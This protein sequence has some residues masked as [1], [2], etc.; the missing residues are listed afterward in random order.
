MKK[1]IILACLAIFGMGHLSMSQQTTKDSLATQ[2]IMREAKAVS[3]VEQDSVIVPQVRKSPMAVAKFTSNTMYLKVVYGQP[4]KRGR[5]IFGELEPYGKVWRTGAN[6]ATEITATKDF[7]IGGK[8]L[9]AGTY[10]LFTIP[11]ENK[12]TV[13]VNS[14]LGQWGAYKYNPEKDLV[15][16]EVP[17]TKPEYF[18]E[19]FTIEFKDIPSGAEMELL[20]GDT[21]VAFP[22][23]FSK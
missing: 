21:R 19:A 4:Y 6:E 18:Y 13:I 10:T 17:L 5:T 15:S 9:K 16:F 12:W 3:A 22:I 23:E 14:D 2:S 7:R 8:L 20:W 1:N 11:N